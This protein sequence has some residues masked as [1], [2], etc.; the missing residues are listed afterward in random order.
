M[1]NTKICDIIYLYT[2]IPN[3]DAFERQIMRSYYSLQIRAEHPTVVALGCFDGLHIG[4]SAVICTAVDIAKKASL[5]SAVCTFDAPPKNFF[6]RGSAPAITDRSEK[7]RLASALGT[8]VF[9]SL[10]FNTEISSLSPNDFFD[11]I[12]VNALRASHIVCGF[13][14]KFGKNA[15]GNTETLKKLCDKAGISLTCLAPVELDGKTISSSII[16][17][18]LLAGNIE[19]ANKYLGH[20]FSLNSKVIGG[21]K[22]ARKL[23]FPTLNQAFPEDCIVPA[24]GVYL[25]QVIT[26][27]GVKHF[28]ITNVGVRPTVGNRSLR[29]E[30]HIFDFD[31]DLYGQNVRI[32]FLHFLRPE[33]AFSSIDALSAQVNEDIEQAKKAIKDHN[34][35]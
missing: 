10:P 5:L 23:G 15:A 8:D 34:I 12:L 21:K 9:L 29:A 7:E 17:H 30:T 25:T 24:N 1:T 22:L 18:E 33:K 19:S 28:G 32:E 3:F 6:I 4:H 31:G 2:G 11:K 26:K 13:N 16:R 35:H 14:Y 27:D 20:P